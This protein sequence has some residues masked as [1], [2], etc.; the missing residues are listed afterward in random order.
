LQEDGLGYQSLYRYDSLDRLIE[1]EDA[2]GAVTSYG[3]DA[4]GNRT[5]VTDA[6]GNATAFNYDALVVQKSRERLAIRGYSNL[7]KVTERGIQ[8]DA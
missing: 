1:S 7:S 4:E 2:L 6:Q 3:Y 8:C 5:R